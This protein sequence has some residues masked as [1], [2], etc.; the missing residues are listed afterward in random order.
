[1]SKPQLDLRVVEELAA[2][3]VRDAPGAVLQGLRGELEKLI[4]R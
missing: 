4:P 2:K 1:L 3:T